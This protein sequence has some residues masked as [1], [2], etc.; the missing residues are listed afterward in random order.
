MYYICSE[1]QWE[2]VNKVVS[3]FMEFA[4][5]TYILFPL[6]LVDNKK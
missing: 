1:T 6:Y 2:I 3:L 5:S 4:I